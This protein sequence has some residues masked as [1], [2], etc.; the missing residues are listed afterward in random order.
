MKK[1]IALLAILVVYE[2]WAYIDAWLN[3]P[4][5]FVQ[6]HFG[7]VVLYAT[8]WCGYCQRARKLFEE[9]GIDYVEYDIEKSELGKEQY[10]QLNGQGV[11]LILYNG[12]VLRG[13][14]RQ[15]IMNLVL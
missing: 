15:A 8:E 10:D 2:K 9:K 3:P 11:P 4:P 6:D 13:F 1:L 14:S 5:A 7:T 12:E